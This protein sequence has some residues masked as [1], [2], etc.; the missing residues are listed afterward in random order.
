MKEKG[1]GIQE[2][3][4]IAGVHPSTVSRALNG[5]SLVKEETARE[6]RALAAKHGYIPDDVA[7]SLCQGKT[8]TLGILVPEISNSFYAKIVDAIESLMTPKGYSIILTG[9]RFDPETELQAIRTM[10][11]KRVDALIVCDPSQEGAVQLEVLAKRMPVIVCDTVRVHE[12]LDCVS[13]DETRGMLQGLSYL[14]S[15]GHT[16]IGCISDRHTGRRMDIFARM[17][18]ENGVSLQQEY[19]FRG[20]DSGVESGYKGLCAMLEKGTLP[21]ALFAARDNIA[22]GILRAAAEH[23]IRI[24]EE[25]SILG[26]DDIPLSDYLSRKLTTIRQPAAQIGE[27]AAELLQLR[28]SDRQKREPVSIRLVPELV[29]RESA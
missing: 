5:S 14:L 10:A 25:L 3:A 13:V 16:S 12:T 18:R 27:K 20:A 29:V 4:R 28:L 15:R 23:K 9:T 1:I 21:K 26:Y 22:V 19:F 7:K 8:S 2:L 24:P 17:L 6:I 11:S